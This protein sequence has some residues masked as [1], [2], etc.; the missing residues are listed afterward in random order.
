MGPDACEMLSSGKPNLIKLQYL[1]GSE[2][3]TAQKSGSFQ[4]VGNTQGKSPVRV[5]LTAKEARDIDE[6]LSLSPSQIFFDGTVSL[7]GE[8]VASQPTWLAPN[9][10]ILVIDA[11]SG[12]TLERSF[13]HA[14]CSQPLR[15]GDRYGS[16][17]IVELAFIDKKGNVASD[18]CAARQASLSSVGSGEGNSG[19]SGGSGGKSAPTLAIT[20]TVAGI[21]VVALV[22][23]A[24]AFVVRHSR[25]A[26]AAAADLDFAW[27][28]STV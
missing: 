19:S 9:I 12:E 18:S 16:M 23:L 20:A 15:V 24:A 11:S 5:Y 21:A 10:Y 22:A 2:I 27:D 6:V 8:I 28:D 14:S 7:T 4:V 25:R 26:A 1:A 13:F 17:E 3:V